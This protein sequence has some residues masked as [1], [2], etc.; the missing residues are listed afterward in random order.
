MSRLITLLTVAIAVLAA[1]APAVAVAAAGG[2]WSADRSACAP[3]NDLR[4]TCFARYRT[5]DGPAAPGARSGEITATDIRR[6][7]NLP[8]TGGAGRT[9]AIVDA[10]DEPKAEADLAVY[11]QRFGLPPC[12]SANGCFR[13]VNQ[14]GRRSPATPT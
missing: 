12:T 13:K 2:S 7:Y 5:W 11:R 6:A 9:I 14:N 8:S 3:A 1:G 10:Q 4:F